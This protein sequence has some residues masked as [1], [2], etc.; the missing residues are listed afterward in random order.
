MPKP[1]YKTWDAMNDLAALFSHRWIAIPLILMLSVKVV[2][3][4][5][6]TFW[7]L[8]PLMALTLLFAIRM[9]A[10]MALRD[11]ALLMSIYETRDR[12]RKP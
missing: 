12:Q 2:S 1:A 3:L 8:I 7:Y 10:A 4:A 5:P 11:R 9:S 6:V